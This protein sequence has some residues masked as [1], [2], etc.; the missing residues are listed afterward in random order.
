[1]FRMVIL[2]RHLRTNFQVVI[3]ISTEELHLYT[4]AAG[5]EQNASF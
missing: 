2:H 3:S 4:A 1:M 5:F